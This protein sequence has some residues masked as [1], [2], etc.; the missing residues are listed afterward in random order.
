MA[1]WK[2]RGMPGLMKVPR[3]PTPVGRE[4]HTTADVET[5][6]INHSELYEGKERMA[7]KE[8][9]AEWG[10]NPAVAMRGVKPWFNSGRT[11]VADSGFASV[12]LAKGLAHHGMYLIGNVKGG[13]AGFPKKWLLEKVPTRGDKAVASSSFTTASGETWSMLAAA[14]RDKQPMALLGT[15]GSSA[16]GQ[17]LTRHF[18]VIRADGT[19]AVRSATLQQMDIHAT[20]RHAFN[21]VDKNNAKRQGGVS[22]EDV[23][24]TH[25]WWVRDFQLL[26]G[27]SEVNGYLLFRHFHPEGAGISFTEY[28]TLLTRQMLEHPVLMSE[29]GAGTRTRG[30]NRTYMASNEHKLVQTQK[31]QPDSAR[32]SLPRHRLKGRCRYCPRLT[33]W[34]CTCCAAP[35]ASGRHRGQLTVMYV[36]PSTCK[37][38]NGC[39]AL[40]C[41]GV[42]PKNK[43]AEGQKKRWSEQR[44]SGN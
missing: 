35:N 33:T 4:S 27:I 5:G 34:Y 16:P 11:V 8:F 40:H 9:V 38:P 21:V 31:K 7:D 19:F 26:F 41:Q 32:P 3:K 37:V 42:E 43:R 23:W 18:T 28:R 29:R 22:F 6:V 13:H 36:C 1:Q 24:K 30:G 39:F 17:T 10:K 44:A 12:K 25:S 2:G 14:D 20:Y 15:A